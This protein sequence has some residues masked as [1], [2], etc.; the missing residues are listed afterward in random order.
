MERPNFWTTALTGSGFN[1]RSCDGA[2][3]SAFLPVY[4]VVVSIRAPV[5]ERLS[6]EQVQAAAGEF[7]SALL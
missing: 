1:P 5:M 2:T 3:E 6:A 7:Q 4:T